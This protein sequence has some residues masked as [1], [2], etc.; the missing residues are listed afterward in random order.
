[1][2]ARRF[3]FLASARAGRRTRGLARDTARALGD[4]VEI[5]VVGDVDAVRACVRN[6]DDAVVPV[7]VGGDGTAN[8]VARA[9][10]AEGMAMRPMGVIP[11]GTGNAF[12][13][14]IGAGRMPEALD[15]LRRGVARPIDVMVTDHPVLPLAL[16][17][18][19]AGF[20]GEFL[21][22]VAARRAR[23]LPGYVSPWLFAMLAR[24]GCG[25][26]LICD[27]EVVLRRDENSHSAGV[28]NLPCYFFGRRVVPEADPADGMAHARV[29]LRAVDYWRTLLG[30]AGR[31]AAGV[32]ERLFRR[33][34]LE[35]AGPV[36]AD[37][38]AA[39]GGAFEIVVE[40]GGL[41]LLMGARAWRGS[42]P[43]RFRN[44][45]A[46]DGSAGH[47][48]VTCAPPTAGRPSPGSRPA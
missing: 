45:K 29:Y 31:P 16:V 27:G 47:L 15:A 12:A 48:P 43:P 9:L 2:P 3:L 11:A 7:A 5:A 39:A 42:S 32:R 41:C 40:P 8:L 28:Y 17:S 25:A 21:A 30:S 46:R 22:G 36:Q 33:A 14:S 10:R 1:M 23:G 38:E 18:F 44:R 13:H 19:S 34:R 24:S 20:E 4:S 35:T 37:G 6:A 26:T